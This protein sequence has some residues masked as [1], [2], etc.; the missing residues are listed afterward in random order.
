MQLMWGKKV[1]FMLKFQDYCKQESGFLRFQIDLSK[2][3]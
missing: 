1:C 2:K 3:T